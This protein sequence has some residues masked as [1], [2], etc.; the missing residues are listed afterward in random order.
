MMESMLDRVVTPGDVVSLTNLP[1]YEVLATFHVLEALGIIKVVNAKGNYRVYRLTPI[2][3]KL[4]K[5][6]ESSEELLIEVRGEGKAPA[7][8]QP[9][10]GVSAE[11]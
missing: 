5:V 6:L 11:A 4:L 10:E 3:V 8:N 7:S 1:R 2:G 9:S